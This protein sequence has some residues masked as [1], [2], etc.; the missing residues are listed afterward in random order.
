MSRG[1]E[2]F[3]LSTILANTKD[4]GFSEVVIR[5]Q[6]GEKNAGMQTILT[7]NGFAETGTLNHLISYSFDLTGRQI[8]PPPSWFSDMATPESSAPQPVLS[9]A[10]ANTK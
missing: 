8:N 2:D 5:F 7:N 6:R 9:Q 10:T 3:V 4:D 1:V